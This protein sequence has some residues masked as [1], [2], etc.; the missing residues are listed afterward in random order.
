MWGRNESD[1]YDKLWNYS[2]TSKCWIIN[3]HYGASID[4]DI[5]KSRKKFLLS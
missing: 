2:S 3:G 5:K 1:V 4:F